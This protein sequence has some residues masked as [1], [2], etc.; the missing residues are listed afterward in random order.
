LADQDDIWLSDKLAWTIRRLRELNVSA[1]SSNVIAIWPNGSTTLIEKSQRQ[2]RLDFLFESAGP[3]CTYLITSEAAA[4]FRLFLLENR[5]EVDSVQFHDWML[6]A[7]ARSHCFL[8]HID[9]RPMMYYRQ[10]DQNEYGANSGA[11]AFLR[12]FKNVRSGWYRAQILKIARLISDG[13]Q[14][15][16]E[17]AAA[18]SLVERQTIKARVLLAGRVKHLRRKFKDRVLLLLALALGGI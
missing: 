3:G 12:R 18:V 1:I 2:R 10:H 8:W 15:T 17:C 16:D 14:Y 6:Y 7:W 11:A 13:A 4:G 5:D 9:S